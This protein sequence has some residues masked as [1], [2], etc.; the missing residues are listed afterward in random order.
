MAKSVL[1]GISAP[2]RVSSAP[3]TPPV[4]RVPVAPR[5]MV[6]RAVM[7]RANMATR[8]V[9]RVVPRGLG[10][11]TGVA[12]RPRTIQPVPKKRAI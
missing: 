9:S 10:K 4:A 2:A 7:P 6:P 8:A 12:A 5:P 1:T 3:K 11:T